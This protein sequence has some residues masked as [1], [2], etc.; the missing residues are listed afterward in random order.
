MCADERKSSYA[1]PILCAELQKVF[2]RDIPLKERDEWEAWFSTRQQEH[3]QHTAEIVWLETELDERVYA[4]FDLTPAEIEI[5]E[6]STKY[7]YGEV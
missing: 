2:R 1:C 3:R 7:R 4:L 5:I 6:T